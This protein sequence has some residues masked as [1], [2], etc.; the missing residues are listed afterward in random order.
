MIYQI[1]FWL[2]L[3]LI[4]SGGFTY[5]IFV[6]RFYYGWK[7]YKPQINHKKMLVSVVV[8]ARNEAPNLQRLMSCRLSQDYPSEMYEIV[9]ADDDSQDDTRL[10]ICR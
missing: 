7:R 6:I 1:F 5:I 8:V 4:T 2:L 3:A 9:F 10:V